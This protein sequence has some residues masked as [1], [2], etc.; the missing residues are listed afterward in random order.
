MSAET[1]LMEIFL[2]YES[3]K[4]ENVPWMFDALLHDC[5]NCVKN[6]ICW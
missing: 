5:E 2:F 4:F 1:I 3:V 6:Q